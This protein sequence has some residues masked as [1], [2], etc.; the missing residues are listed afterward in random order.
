VSADDQEMGSSPDAEMI[1]A[2]RRRVDEASSPAQLAQ[3]SSQVGHAL[4]LRQLSAESVAALCR[5]T[6]RK[7]RGSPDFESG[8]WSAISD[9]LGASS[10]ALRESAQ[11]DE[12]R[13]EIDSRPALRKV[14]LA[15]H[16]R[17]QTPTELARAVSRSAI[18]NDGRITR[19]LQAL[20]ELGLVEPVIPVNDKRVRRRQLTARGHRLA[21]EISGRKDKGRVSVTPIQAPPSNEEVVESVISMLRLVES[22]HD[23]GLRELY[24]C[25]GRI[26]VTSNRFAR[27]VVAV[28]ERRGLIDVTP[29]ERCRWGREQQNNRWIPFLDSCASEPQQ[30]KTALSQLP[31]GFVLCTDLVH[32]W[33]LALS[34]ISD[35]VR[36]VG[37]P[38]YVAK[39]IKEEP[40]RTVILDDES[41]V[42][43]F[44]ADAGDLSVYVAALSLDRSSIV[45]DRVNP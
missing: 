39:A 23:V 45:F 34:S 44:G 7:R 19:R 38:E 42:G 31:D 9:V 29:E 15:L 2:L 17:S 5:Q 22:C 21:F 24:A 30:L 28:A 8:Y 10:A 4:A 12:L 16:G 27:F 32:K 26:G 3:L 40:V 1:A 43:M 14:L 33:R 11:R 36:D 6:G 20:E 18:A 37:T 25:A 41:R 13:S 35:R